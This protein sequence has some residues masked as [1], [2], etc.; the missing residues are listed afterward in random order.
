MTDLAA[1]LALKER[2]PRTW[3][4][5]F[6]RHGT[7]TAVQ[8]AT[9]PPLLEG[10]N[11]IVCAPTASGK[12][13]AAM[14][15]LVER[16]CHHDS[17]G[18]SIL[19]LTPTRALVNDLSARLAHPLQLLRVS[20]GMRTRDL[21]TFDPAHPPNVLLT[22]PE[23]ADALLAG[24]ARIFANLRAIVLDELHLLDGTPRGDQ[25][26]VILSRL[27]R[28]RDYARTCGDAPD[29]A[30]QYAALSAT[31]AHPA[32]VAARYVP[33]ARVIQVGGGRLIDAEQIRLSVDS[34]DAL[35]AYLG[36][37][38]ARGWR[39][40]LVF[41]N[42][43][44]E[45]EAYA[46][47]VRGRSPFGGAVYVHY[48]NIDAR[49]RQ[50]I[51]HHYGDA[52]AAIC[53]ASSTLELGIDI[54]DVDVVIL[55]GPPGSAESFLQRVGRGNR[56]RGVTRVACLYRTPLERLLFDALTKAGSWSRELEQ[57][58]SDNSNSVLPTRCRPAVAIQQIFSLIKASP[59]GAVRPAELDLLFEGLLAPADLDAILAHLHHLDYLRPGRPG[60]W[61]PGPRLNDLF[62]R[63]ASASC[64]LSIYSNIQGGAGRTVD[65][66][67]QHTHQTMARVDPQWLDRP[68]LTLEGR[69]ITVEWYDGEAM[70][71]AAYEGEDVAQRL[72]YRSERQLL[73]YDLAQML[74]VHLGLAAGTAPFIA[75]RPPDEAGDRHDG[76]ERLASGRGWWWFHWLG[77]LYARA[78][79]D[80]LRYRLAAS[81]TTQPGLCIHL[82]AE[83]Q[84]PPSWTEAQ[85]VRYLEDT[86]RELEALLD[87]GPFQ[88][89]L[90]VHLRRRAVV[91]Q[92]NVP[93]FLEA[94]SALRPSVAPDALADD[95]AELLL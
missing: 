30:L 77:D 91:E 9:I 19:Y 71:V 29:A 84:A 38:R 2:L 14:A 66:R 92:F 53:F 68:V 17:R 5:F 70:W 50:E 78:V 36:T 4:A 48:S 3:P 87:L 31:F 85:V 76:R 10:H 75:A 82:P 42:T 73:S 89:L 8:L 54:G 7:F 13:E 24:H 34:A 39:K 62:D 44:A 60:D 46:A 1:R 22:T 37:L 6:E 63:Q 86:Y 18:L 41:C 88:R 72:R 26:C 11:V 57:G 69:P 93:R 61:R 49:R 83:P 43:R 51:E 56:R 28:I 52:E 25:V 74:P 15:P 27:R 80:L 40:A 23:S 45:V 16:H 47:A 64:P 20:I 33:A 90:P 81:E 35:L 95:L 94:I 32:A 58:A 65:I 21:S 59:T 67:D 55:I 79:L 12:T